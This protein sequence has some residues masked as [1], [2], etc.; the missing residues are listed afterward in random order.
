MRPFFNKQ[1]FILSANLPTRYVSKYVLSICQKREILVLKCQHAQ[2]ELINTLLYFSTII[3]LAWG[4]TGK[5][6]F[7]W[8]CSVRVWSLGG[9]WRGEEV[10]AQERRERPSLGS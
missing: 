10:A 5:T 6:G 4:W 8:V 3:I 1:P 2:T 9:R 7:S